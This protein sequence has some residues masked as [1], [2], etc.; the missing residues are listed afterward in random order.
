MALLPRSQIIM[1]G[2]QVALDVT[3]YNTSGVV[4]DTDAFPSV[5]IVQPSGNVIVP[6]TTAGVYR[7]STGLYGYTFEVGTFPQ[8]GIWRDI[9]TGAVSGDIRVQE[10]MFAVYITQTPAINSDGYVHLGDDPGFNYSQVAIQNINLLLKELKARL[11]SRGI[12]VSTDEFGN[13][14]YTD[15]DI[16]TTD[17]LVTFLVTSMQMF[18]ETPAFTYFTFDD[19][20]IINTFSGILVQ[21]ASLIALSSQALIERG[22]E[23]TITDSSVSYTPPTLSDIL[24]TQWSTEF[25]NWNERVKM[26]KFNMKP[27]PIGLGIMGPMSS[28]PQAARL[29]LLR[30]RR[31]W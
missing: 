18:N 24:S 31:I 7:T 3:F 29:R 27:A 11:N 15:C 6:T 5:Q 17:Q 10:N 13:K 14:I 23:M 16:F 21:G 19:T 8:V 22:R 20:P 1:P 30:A 9:W 4:A 2:N 26:I 28:S 12:H 25:T